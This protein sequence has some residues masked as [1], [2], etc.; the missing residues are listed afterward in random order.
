[1]RDFY[2]SFINFGCDVDASYYRLLW[3]KVHKNLIKILVLYIARVILKF[4][5]GAKVVEWGDL[6]ILV[7]EDSCYLTFKKTFLR[8][9][10]MECTCS[11]S[12]YLIIVLY[13]YHYEIYN[14]ILIYRAIVEKLMTDQRLIIFVILFKC[15]LIN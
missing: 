5:L 14:K 4:C 15:C 8:C 12:Q 7:T 10:Q 6:Y 13:R 11:H 3:N 9:S 1:M 2:S